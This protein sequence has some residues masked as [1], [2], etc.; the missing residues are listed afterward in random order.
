MAISTWPLSTELAR[1]LNPMSYRGPK[2]RLR[3]NNRVVK[4]D[5][6]PHMLVTAPLPEFINSPVKERSVMATRISTWSLSSYEE[7]SKEEVL[8]SISLPTVHARRSVPGSFWPS[9]MFFVISSSLSVPLLMLRGQR[10]IIGSSIE[11]ATAASNRTALCIK[12]VAIRSG[13]RVATGI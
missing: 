9:I 5:C 2:G 4:V 6:A 13:W 7:F 10:G 8:K 3:Q 11:V 12:P 1:F